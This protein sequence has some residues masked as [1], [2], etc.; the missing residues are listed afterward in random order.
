MDSA[1]FSTDSLEIDTYLREHDYNGLLIEDTPCYE[2]L[3]CLVTQLEL[4]ME[5]KENLRAC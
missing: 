1:S 2:N 3:Q 4:L 5:K